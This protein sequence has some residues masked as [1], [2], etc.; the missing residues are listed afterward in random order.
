[1]M[2]RFQSFFEGVVHKVEN[3]DFHFSRYIFLFVALLFVRLSLEF[4][5]SKRLFTQDDII[6]IGLWFLFIVLAFM[7]QL[8][9]F[10]GEKM[11][12][13][14]KL[15]IV[16]FSIA[17]TAPILDLIIT[18]GVGAKM[19]YLSLTTWNDI[20][21]SY[22][23]LGGSSMSRGATPGIRIEIILLLLASFNYVRTKRRSIIWG[24]ASVLSIYTILFLSGAI[25]LLLGIFNNAFHLQYQP[26]DRSTILLLLTLDILFIF[27]AILLYSSRTVIGIFKLVP[28]GAWVISFMMACIGS[29]L[30]LQN[31]PDN[32]KLTPTT[33]FHF[34]LLWMMGVCFAGYTG[35]QQM[36]LQSSEH[37]I[38]Y[39]HAS[40]GIKVF[41]VLISSMISVKTFFATGM[42]WGLLFILYETPL[43]LRN[44]P[45]LRNVLEAIAVFAASCIGFCS[46]NAPLIGFPA[47][48][49][50]LILL[51]VFLCGFITDIH[52]NA[53]S[54]FPW[55]S[56]KVV[57]SNFL[58]KGLLSLFIL[59]F[60]TWVSL[61]LMKDYMSISFFMLSSFLPIGLMWSKPLKTQFILFSF[62]PA[63]LILLRVAMGK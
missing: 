43:M 35:I 8:K 25:P 41:I 13:V 45:V 22:F 17:L 5:S 51:G 37:R 31:Y 7:V 10:S 56:S 50:G 3:T 19:N 58:F 33:I 26:D 32:F 24:I 53:G 47:I 6:H 2:K 27:M 44:I 9:I 40:H 46:F 23:T 36:Q 49:L 18:K 4:F 38:K 54:I 61:L 11:I 15:S 12:K 20:V 30:A 21:H 48:W 1:M 57:Y 42:L 52:L 29:A 34:P 59:A 39:T 28:W 63:C 55:I 16:F 62:L 14:A 60:F